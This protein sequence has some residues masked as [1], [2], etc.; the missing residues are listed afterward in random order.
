MT[1]KL[2][3][4]ALGSETTTVELYSSSSGN[5][6]S[7]LAT[8]TTTVTEDRFDDY[9]FNCSSGCQL[10]ANTSYFIVLTLTGARI[11]HFWGQ[12]TSGSETNT[13]S[14]A[15]WT[16]ANDAKYRDGQNGPWLNE[17]AVKLMKVSW[18]TPTAPG[19]VAD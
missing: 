14:N 9:V 5:P 4:S 12:N 2:K 17:G 7:S 3:L 10:S 16:I 15:G 1:L 18:E 8:M 19:K 11:Q 6:G 13:P